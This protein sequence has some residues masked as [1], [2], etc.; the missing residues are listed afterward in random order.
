MKSYHN[1]VEKEADQDIEQAV[2]SFAKRYFNALEDGL[3]KELGV[4][5]REAP[6]TDRYAANNLPL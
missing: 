1:I 6:V 3:A 2:L 4:Y 5:M